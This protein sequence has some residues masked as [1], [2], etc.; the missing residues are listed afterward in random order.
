MRKWRHAIA[1]AMLVAAGA[2]VWGRAN[3]QTVM[4]ECPTVYSGPEGTGSLMASWTD[5]S[6]WFG[7]YVHFDND[8]NQSDD[9]FTF[10]INCTP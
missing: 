9:F 3:A 5:G 6:N 10:V 4:P 1:V 2:G 7:Q 8:D